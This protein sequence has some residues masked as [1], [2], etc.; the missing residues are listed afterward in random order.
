[1]DEQQ[2]LN[3]AQPPVADRP[4]TEIKRMIAHNSLVWRFCFYGFIK[5]LQFFE[6]YLLLIL[7]EWGYNLFDIGLLTAIMH[8]LTYIFEVP[9]GVIADHLGKKNILLISFCFYMV[10]FCFYVFGERSFGFLVCASICYGLGEAFRSGTHKAMIMVWLDRQGLSKY[11]TFIYSRTRSFSNL[12]SA[13][14][15]V[16]S[17]AIVIMFNYQLVFAISV[18]PFVLDFALVASYPAYMNAT[19]DTKGSVRDI[20]ADTSDAL[21]LLASD[22]HRRRPLLSSASFQAVFSSLKHYIQP[23]LALH[24][25]G[26]LAAWGVPEDQQLL[27]TKVLVGVLY[28]L[29]YLCSAAGTRHSHA[30][31]CVFKSDKMAIDLLFD[32]ECLLLLAVGLAVAARAVSL[33]LPLF[34]GLYVVQNL[35]KPWALAA[36]SDLMGKQRRATVLSVESLVDTLL[37][38]ALAPL[39]GYVAHAHS[40]E[41]AFLG[42]GGAALLLNRTFLSGGWEGARQPAPPGQVATAGMPAAAHEGAS[43]SI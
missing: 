25:A 1:M 17:I 42:L 18:V 4:E 22:P 15:A 5:N 6:A 3:E 36:V 7:L 43:L 21:R 19:P 37:E 35:W 26:I 29:F 9:S 20:V 41:A 38:F 27:G 14:N 30:L 34:L 31:S 33:A 8:S 10:S 13:L 24:G 28:A 32:L 2:R 12:G 16:L 39:V 11:K 23:I 40:V